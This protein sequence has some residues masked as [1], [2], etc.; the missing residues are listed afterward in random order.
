LEHVF[1]ESIPSTDVLE[2]NSRVLF[3]SSA[4]WITPLWAR[5]AASAYTGSKLLESH[6]TPVRDEAPC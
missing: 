4:V 1:L 2:M 3:G 6:R 5:K